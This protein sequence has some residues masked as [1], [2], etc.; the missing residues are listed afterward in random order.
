M[1]EDKTAEALLDAMLD[2]APDDVDKREGSVVYDLLAPAA[3]E[4]S[5]AYT[6]L[7]TLLLLA[8]ADTTE[9]EWLD[10]YVAM[11]G[12]ERKPAV[13]A[14]GQVTFTGPDGTIIPA[15]TRLVTDDVEP[16]Y[17]VTTADATIAGG[18]ATVSAEAEE[19]GVKGNVSAGEITSLAIDE[20]YFEVVSVTNN[21]PFTGGVDEESD[22]ELRARLLDR[23]RRPVTSGNAN[24]YR[25]WALEVAGVGDAKVYPVWN[26]PGTVKVVLLDTEKKA[27]PQSIVDAVA[28]HIESVRPVGANVTVVGATEVPINISAILTLAPGVVIEDVQPEIETA[29]IEYLKSIAFVE[30]VVRYSR[31]ANLILNTNGVSDYSNLTVNGGTSNI[32]IA[33]GSVAVLGTVTL[34]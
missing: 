3:I 13:K 20:E 6:E 19:G 32:T 12:L 11:F 29:V 5:L 10:K 9:G 31:I 21:E 27:P 24:H 2:N 26:G 7:D 8:F 4:F 17:F 1:F 28:T 34:A 30:P 15:G 33:D 23:L 16:V 25:Q 22:D 18:S 14:T